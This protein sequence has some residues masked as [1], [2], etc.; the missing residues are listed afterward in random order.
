MPSSHR[1]RIL[2]LQLSVNRKSTATRWM[3]MWTVRVHAKKVWSTSGSHLKASEGAEKSFRK[4]RRRRG[5][6][7][8][9]RRSRGRH[10]REP[11]HSARPVNEPS[12]RRI[13][14]FLRASDHFYERVCQFEKLMKQ[15]KF[16]RHWQGSRSLPMQPERYSLWKARWGKLRAHISTYGE[17][18]LVSTG[19]GPSF[20]FFLEQRLGFLL[21]PRDLWSG[22][23]AY[24]VLQDV[25]QRLEIRA[26]FTSVR[27]RPDTEPH[28]YT[29]TCS[30]CQTAFGSS[31]RCRR[32]PD[33]F[34]LCASD[35]RRGG[36]SKRRGRYVGRQ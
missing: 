18:V 31:T 11:S 6:R 10:P 27:N 5:Q 21:H 7:V 19:I 1:R 24:R 9:K 15:S 22:V 14:S 23:T 32:C 2:R 30:W 34:R 35:R 28:Y 12:N 25:A 36:R 17:H 26:N 3:G 8:G 13:N 29:I 33:C 20:A 16:V 4:R